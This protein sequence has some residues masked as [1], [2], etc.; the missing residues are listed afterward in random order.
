MLRE[1][2]EFAGAE[3][4]RGDGSLSMPDWLVAHCHVSRSR[5]RTLVEAAEKVGELP[6]LSDA[7]SEGRLTLD[8][9]APLA[10]VATPE[11]DAEL[12]RASEHWTP[13]QARR[14]AAEVRGAT[15]SD[16]AAQFRRRFVRFDDGIGDKG[17]R[18]APPPPRAAP[19]PLRF[20]KPELGQ[21]HPSPLLVRR[22]GPANPMVALLSMVR[23]SSPH[24]P[25]SAPLAR[26][27]REGRGHRDEGKR[28]ALRRDGTAAPPAAHPGNG[29][30]GARGGAWM[31][32]ASTSLDWG[33]S[34]M[35]L[36]SAAPP[37]S[38]MP[39]TPAAALAEPLNRGSAP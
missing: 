12:A 11:T 36:P 31:R 39:V 2:A 32:R 16:S 14:L 19:R 3:T 30:E 37:G 27:G 18:N 38:S 21:A 8:V 23:G 15:A 13:K 6:A 20:E 35:F 7:L 24:A 26:G 10:A 22:M 34:A 4:W 25:T 17:V 5:A 1:I 29:G 33:A 9:F 28:A